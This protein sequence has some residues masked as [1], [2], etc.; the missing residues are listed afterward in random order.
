MKYNLKELQKKGSAKISSKINYLIGALIVVVL[1]VSLA[2]TIFSNLGEI[3]GAPAWL[4][5]VLVI[6][7]GAGLVFLVVESFNIR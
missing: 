3:E 5:P 7:V 6:V 2:P 4:A 1:A